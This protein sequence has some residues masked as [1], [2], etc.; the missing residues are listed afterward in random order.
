V[1]S[2]VHRAD[3]LH[4]EAVACDVL[5]QTTNKSYERKVQVRSHFRAYLLKKFIIMQVLVS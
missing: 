3:F 5:L 4:I 1:D 2:L